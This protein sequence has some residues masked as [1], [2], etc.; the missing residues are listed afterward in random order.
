MLWRDDCGCHPQVIRFEANR[1]EIEPAEIVSDFS[2][3]RMRQRRIRVDLALHA[4][5]QHQ[6]EC[7]GVGNDQLQLAITIEGIAADHAKYVDGGIEGIPGYYGQLIITC[8]I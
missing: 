5:P 8:P 1:I 4:V 2:R 6:A 7:A 3:K